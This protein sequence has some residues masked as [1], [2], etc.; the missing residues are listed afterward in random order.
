MK[1]PRPWRV[2]TRPLAKASAASD[3]TVQEGTLVDAVKNFQQ[4]HGRTAEGR[5]T[6]PTIADLNV[7][8]ATRVR[9][10]QPTLERWRWLPVEYRSLPIAVNLAEFR[11]RAHDENLK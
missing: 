8:L 10:M 7:Q 3:G 2:V 5:I 9:Q 1:Q 11:A 4:R 6:E